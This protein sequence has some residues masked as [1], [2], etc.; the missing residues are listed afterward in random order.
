M[1][2]VITCGSCGKH[3]RVPHA[4]S[5]VPACADCGRR[6][7]WLVETD[8]DGFDDAV[9]ARVPVL[10][11]LWAPWRG[12]CRLVAPIL[13]QLA[14]DRAGQ[15]KIVK[16]NVDDAPELS[17][18]LAVLGIPTMLLFHHGREVARQVGALPAA[19]LEE[20]LHRYATP[21]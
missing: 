1:A 10:V 13:Q 9:Q 16:V 17:A 15:L 5:G 3:N 21:A 4:A 8:G 7:P 12:P 2:A 19:A 20:W 6:L 11:D 18:R 14:A